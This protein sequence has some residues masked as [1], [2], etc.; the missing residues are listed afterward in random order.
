MDIGK[1]TKIVDKTIDDLI[2]T[3][4]L[5]LIQSRLLEK[6]GKY[7][8]SLKQNDPLIDIEELLKKESFS[9]I[10]PIRTRYLICYIKHSNKRVKDL[11]WIRDNKWKFTKFNLTNDREFFKLIKLKDKLSIDKSYSLPF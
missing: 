8:T 7:I 6:S 4:P 3:T 2:G 10:N 1:I 5:Y 11:G 9:D